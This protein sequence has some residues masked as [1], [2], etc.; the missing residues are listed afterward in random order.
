M[1]REVRN[2]ILQKL[3]RLEKCVVTQRLV[4]IAQ[5]EL[6]PKNVFLSPSDQIP[7][8]AKIYLGTH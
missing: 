3:S 7:R 4:Y 2:S 5:R 1:V 8:L 6:D